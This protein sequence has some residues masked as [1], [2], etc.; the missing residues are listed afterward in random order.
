MANTDN[1]VSFVAGGAITEFATVSVDVNGKA[2][3][4]TLPA[5]EACIGVAQRAVSAGDAV[6]VVIGGTTR[7]VAGATIAPATTSLLM[8]EAGG[9]L[10]PFV[11]GSGN[12]SIARI[13]PNTQ[14]AAPADGDQI[15]VIFTGPSNFKS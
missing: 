11:K 6:E 2:V 3:V 12:F 14:H 9:K 13:I 15:K 1:I 8:V 4:T 10:I 5:D 7:A